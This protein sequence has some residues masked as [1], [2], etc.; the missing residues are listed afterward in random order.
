LPEKFPEKTLDYG[1]AVRRLRQERGMTSEALA[2]AAQVSPSYLSEVERGL[3]RPSTDVLAKLA[4][5][6][7][8]LPSQ[9][10]EHVETMTAGPQMLAQSFEPPRIR[11]E[12]ARI[13]AELDF[14]VKG[15]FPRATSQN[16]RRLLAVAQNLNDDDLTALLDLARHLLKKSKGS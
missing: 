9:L 3:K 13:R 6:F 11:Q 14:P 5:A 8:M 4:K 12:R 10:L 2:G 16:L 15:P 7:G 1:S